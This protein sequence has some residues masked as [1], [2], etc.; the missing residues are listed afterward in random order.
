MEIILTPIKNDHFTRI[1]FIGLLLMSLTAF[2]L[3][4]GAAFIASQLPA[5]EESF[6]GQ[7]IDGNWKDGK[8]M[9]TTSVITEQSLVFLT[10][11]SQPQGQWWI[12]EIIP[13]QGFIIQSTA[14][15][16]NMWFNWFIK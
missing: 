9:V 1:L 10:P 13:A 11:I 8:I 4:T 5:V 2:A 6:K 14:L 7:V 12:A 15:N 16:E 3:A